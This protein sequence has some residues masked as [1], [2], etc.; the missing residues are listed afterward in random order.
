[1]YIKTGGLS[2]LQPKS[3]SN[4]AEFKRA[5]LSC[6]GRHVSFVYQLSSGV[7]K[8][9]YISVDLLGLVLDTYTEQPINLKELWDTAIDSQS[10]V[11]MSK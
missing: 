10:H 11:P 6:S 9:T 1:M 8:V 5:V 4:F 3:L 2:D 7:K